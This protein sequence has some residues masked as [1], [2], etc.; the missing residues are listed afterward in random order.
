MVDYGKELVAT[1]NTILPTHYELVLQRGMA[2]PCISWQETNNYAEE[3]GDTIGYSRI[4]YTVKVW[5]N[6]IATIQKYVLEIDK[7]LR[8][9]GFKRTATNEL[10]D[11]NSTMIQKIMT[12]S[13]KAV[14]Q[15]N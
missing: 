4:S 6:D 1:L 15:L 12:Y 11:M 14:E 7:A 2:T 5:A 9:L 10:Y 13:A 8:P 3:E